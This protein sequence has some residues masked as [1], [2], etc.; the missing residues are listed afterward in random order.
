MSFFGKAYSDFKLFKGDFFSEEE[1][2]D[3]EVVVDTDSKND[4]PP[5][6]TRK[7]LTIN[8]YVREVINESR[9][10]FINNYAFGA[11]VDH[12]LKLR[13][14]DMLEGAIIVS[15]KPFCP[16]NFRLNDRNLNDI[17]SILNIAEFEPLNGSVS[18]TPNP[19][20]YYFQ[21]I[22]RTLLE[23]YFFE[24]KKS[25]SGTRAAREEKA[26]SGSPHSSSLSASTSTSPTTSSGGSSS[27]SSS[28]SDARS[29]TKKGNNKRMR[30]TSPAYPKKQKKPAKEAKL[31]PKLKWTEVNPALTA[32]AAAV[33]SKAKSAKKPTPPAKKDKK[34]KTGKQL[35]DKPKTPATSI[36]KLNTLDKEE[37]KALETMHQQATK[38]SRNSLLPLQNLSSLLFSTSNSFNKA[39]LTN[40]THDNLDQ[41]LLKD[42]RIS[43]KALKNVHEQPG[44][45][46]VF[47]VAPTVVVAAAALTNGL[48]K[49]HSSNSVS[50]ARSTPAGSV[51]K[52][53]TYDPEEAVARKKFGDAAIESLDNY[54]SRLYFLFLDVLM[55]TVNHWL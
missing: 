33:V 30:S 21:R 5:A 6:L 55:Y 42:S 34:E 15:S 10:I 51:T 29:R 49:S 45:T 16:L 2:V 54:L 52:A 46:A 35:S 36:D 3:L 41:K 7:R 53:R 23:K 50:S 8:E 37:K 19:V 1:F 32:A 25:Q 43:P 40:L 12:Q 14:L 24:C 31:I 27:F 18:W 17:G 28:G 11:E 26:S 38:A 13:F 22:D 9:L 48:A 4:E 39:S 44:A 47:S 20:S